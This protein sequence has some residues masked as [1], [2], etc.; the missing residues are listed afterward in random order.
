MRTSQENSVRARVGAEYFV[1]SAEVVDR[2]LER[3]VLYA[4]GAVL[5]VRWFSFLVKMRRLKPSRTCKTVWTV[6]LSANE[7]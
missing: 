6:Y 5:C 2:C 4:F 3:C 7:C 1:A